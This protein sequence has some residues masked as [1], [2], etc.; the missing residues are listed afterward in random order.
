MSSDKKHKNQK[1]TITNENVQNSFKKISLGIQF[2]FFANI[3]NTGRTRHKADILNN[4]Q[5]LEK[6][7][8]GAS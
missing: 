1:K 5:K 4:P 7:N 3:V 6:Q 8:H 2:F